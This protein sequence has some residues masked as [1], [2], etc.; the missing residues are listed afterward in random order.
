MKKRFLD[1]VGSEDIISIKKVMKDMDE[2]DIKLVSI[3]YGLNGNDIMSKLE[4]CKKFNVDEAAIEK[5]IN[6]IL[7]TIKNNLSRNKR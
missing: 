3:Y 5:R 4:M 2:K 1:D 7:E 6:E